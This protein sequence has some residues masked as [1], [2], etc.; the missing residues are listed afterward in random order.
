MTRSPQPRWLRAPAALLAALFGIAPAPTQTTAQTIGEAGPDQPTISRPDASNRVVRVFDFESHFD[1]PARAE[2]HSIPRYW[3]MA[4]DGYPGTGPRPGF[5]IYNTADLDDTIAFAGEGSVRLTTRGGS[6]SLRLD[7]GVVPVFPGAEYLVSAHVLTRGLSNA[8]AAVRVRYLD[9]ANQPLP[10][11]EAVSDLIITDFP[12]SPAPG[13]WR[14]LAVGLPANNPGAAYLQ[15]DL[16]ILQPREFQPVVL[17]NHQLWAN[18]F[19]ASAWFDEVA[20]VQLPRVRLATSSPVN[21]IRRPQKPVISVHFR[22]LAGEAI[23][24]ELT[25]QDAAGRTIDSA[26]RPLGTGQATWEWEPSVADLGWYRATLDLRAGDRKVGGT[27]LDLVWLPAAPP[28]TGRAIDIN[29]SRFVTIV[30]E[31]PEDGRALLPYLADGTASGVVR[32]PAWSPTQAADPRRAADDLVPLVEA[33]TTQGRQIGFSLRRAPHAAV[34]AGLAEAQDPLAYLSQD[35][36]V[37]GPSLFPFLDK[38]GQTVQRWQVGALGDDPPESPSTAARLSALRTEMAKLVPGPVLAIP[39]PAEVAPTGLS[40]SVGE[41]IVDVPYAAPPGA[42]TLLAD[43][44]AQSLGSNP[45]E[46]VM[47]LGTLPPAQFSRLDS[48]SELVKRTVAFWAAFGPQPG[49]AGGN[50]IT[51]RVGIAQPWDWPSPP[52]DRV[53]PHAELAAWNNLIARL[54]GRRVVGT[55]PAGAGVTCYILAAADGSRTR[56]GALVVWRSAPTQDQPVLNAYLGAGNIT[57]VDMFGNARPVP[58]TG[59]PT[60]HKIVIGD[61]PLF[62]EGVDA[63]LAR[64]V[65]SFHLDPDGIPAISGEHELSILLSN[66]YRTRIDGRITILEPGGLS[67]GIEGRDRSWSVSPRTSAFSIAPGQTT[68]LPVAVSFSPV[69]ESGR[70]PVVA[71]IE[72]TAD[73]AYAPIRAY[74][75]LEVRMDDLELDLSYRMSP[76]VSGPDITLEAHVTNRGDAPATIEL[77]AFA[78]GLSRA[79]ASIADLAPGDTVVR[80][81][82]FPAAADK[83]RGNRIVVSA[84]DVDTKLR[85]NRSIGI[86]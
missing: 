59:T 47:V 35:V 66:P 58:P 30:P 1:D 12:K 3:S 49:A 44:W 62:I 34:A 41:L 33:L 77:T 24:G 9:K 15:I 73:R 71:E 56:A 4:Q 14:T 76:L 55:M 37:W 67:G 17:P 64:F 60:T 86:E 6:V 40:P 29:T 19:P 72:F 26:V 83:L 48:A 38:F 32:I 21:I 16:E 79:K 13:D 50:P 7:P 10:G 8:R 57:A 80:R 70:K 51:A 22:D 84:Q 18:D 65:S 25:L 42:F 31:L 74:S 43:S 28:S 52:H 82:M 5:P 27:Y 53:M 68:R 63:E 54:G 46:L 85:I 11:A 61:H 69:E 23:T 45:P 39:W 81:F 20:I 78:P 36:K 2:I 75:T